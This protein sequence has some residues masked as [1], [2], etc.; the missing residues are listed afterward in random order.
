MPS[1]ASNSATGLLVEEHARQIA[2]VLGVPDFVYAPVLETKGATQREISDGM[3]IC[4]ED[5]LIIQVKARAAEDG[6][7]ARAEHWIRKN[8]QAA[9]RQADGTR[10]R[11]SL[12]QK[13][14]FTSL[15]GYTRTLSGV[16]GWPAAVIIDH[17]EIPEGLT[18]EQSSDTL[19]ITLADWREL[20]AH[21]RSTAAVI[22]YV[23][24]ALGSGLHPRLVLRQSVIW[25][26]RAPTLLPT[27]GARV[28]RCCRWRCSEDP[29]QPTP[30]W[31][32]I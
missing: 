25:L 5:G 29:R 28:I 18:L 20:H 11:L 26:S 27:L 13:V 23:S 32:T 9:S 8:S 16:E 21:L 24:R 12:S 10:R 4:G 6:H 17:P 1:A 15:R 22:S 2:A 19:W 14:T 30:R 3:L 7:A 31:S